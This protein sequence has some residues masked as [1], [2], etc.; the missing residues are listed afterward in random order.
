MAFMSF[1]L[2]RASPDFLPPF[3]L[4]SRASLVVRF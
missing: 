2:R 3:A 4:I 1:F